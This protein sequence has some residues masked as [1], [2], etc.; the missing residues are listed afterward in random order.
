MK[1]HHATLKKAE[2][3]GLNIIT[4]DKQGVYEAHWPEFNQRYYHT[5]AKVLVDM[6]RLNQTLYLEYP[7]LSVEWDEENL[8]FIILF[9]QTEGETEEIG[10]HTGMPDL[11]DV[12]QI[13][14]E[15]DIDT[16][17]LLDETEEP[18]SVVK[19][20]YKLEYAAR[21]N[22]ANCGDWLARALTDAFVSHH[23]QTKV[24]KDG[25]ERTVKGPKVF[26]IVSFV[27]CLELN[28]VDL[29]GKWAKSYYSDNPSKGWQGRFRM[30][31]RQMLEK[32]VLEHG[33]LYL[34][35]DGK[36]QKVL[37]PEEWLD[38]MDEKHK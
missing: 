8:N 1:V 28:E 17:N 23:P 31:G 3:S 34:R 26:D 9:E 2:K 13:A 25:K 4:H 24:G 22:P 11:D 37:P 20:K 38:E 27:D 29:S 18:G 32:K 33:A 10:R 5:D 14:E 35:V 7:G 6:A 15:A 12:L 19:E 30:S 21:G 16:A 36:V